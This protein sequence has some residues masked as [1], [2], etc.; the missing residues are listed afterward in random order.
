MENEK[1][2]LVAKPEYLSVYIGFLVIALGI[3]LV[4]VCIEEEYIQFH[5]VFYAAIIFIF[6]GVMVSVFSLVFSKYEIRFFDNWLEA[7]IQKDKIEKLEY[8]NIIN[9][10]ESEIFRKK[11]IEIY[12]A[13]RLLIIKSDEYRNYDKIKKLLV[14]LGLPYNA[15]IEQTYRVKVN[16]D[17]DAPNW[18]VGTSIALMICLFFSIFIFISIK[19]KND[20]VISTEK[21]I[22]NPTLSEDSYISLHG[23]GYKSSARDTSV[24]L[25]IEN[26]HIVFE[27]EDNILS[28]EHLSYIYNQLQKNEKVSLQILKA[29]YEYRIAKTKKPTFWYNHL[30]LGKIHI[31]GLQHKDNILIPFEK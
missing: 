17:K 1:P 30:R 15:S 2:I 18:I 24:E 31:Y 13:N 11:E 29:D 19:R 26:S 28:V 9:W 16:T 14:E 20:K 12:T 6:I 23:T 5:D 10:K 3:F 4:V 8:R 27:T 7:Q 21:I 22:F 25:K